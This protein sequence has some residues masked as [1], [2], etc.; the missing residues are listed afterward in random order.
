M[1]VKYAKRMDLF[2]KSELGEILKLIEEPNIISFA[3]GL[4]ASELFPVEEM[5]KVTANMYRQ[6]WDERNGGNISYL[7]DEKELSE[8][9]DLNSVIRE[10]P[11]GFTAEK[12]VGKY[13]LVTGTGKYSYDG[14]FNL[15]ENGNVLIYSS[16]NSKN[17]YVYV[18]E[19][20]VIETKLGLFFEESNG[21]YVN[22]DETLTLTQN[23]K[24]NIP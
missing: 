4:P 11:I 7:L 6:G 22:G 15:H 3:G 10:I 8:Y 2:K 19:G 18:K 24:R 21:V 20:A 17:G 12:L 23:D 13:F 1:A 16:V 14:T 9:L 5:K